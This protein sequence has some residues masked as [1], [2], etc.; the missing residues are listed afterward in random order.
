MRKRQNFLIAPLMNSRSRSVLT[1][2]VP[3]R[4]GKGEAGEGSDWQEMKREHERRELQEKVY[5]VIRY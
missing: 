4:G 3:A 5:V 1:K 2:A